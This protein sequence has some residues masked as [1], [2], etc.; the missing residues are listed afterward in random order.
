[1][2]AR[3]DTSVRTYEDPYVE[4]RGGVSAI[5]ILTGVL[6]AVGAWFLLTA[7][8]LAGLAAAGLID[9][10]SGVDTIEAGVGAGVA[11]V[12]VEFLAY[13]WGGYT[14]GR[15]ARGAGAINGV[16]V[17]ILSLVV[18]GLIVAAVASLGYEVSINMPFEASRLPFE[19]S[20]AVDYGLGFGIAA[21]AA[22]LLGGLFGGIAGA[23]WHAR[24]ERDATI[25]TTTTGG[26]SLADKARLETE[27][28]RREDQVIRLER[29][30][31]ATSAPAPVRG[32]TDTPPPPPAGGLSDKTTTQ[33][34][35]PRIR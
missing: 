35:A 10:E 15:M 32:R 11:L 1:M 18:G 33:P 13:L 25:A 26:L 5:G 14:A 28:A 6:V 23:R 21:L 19:G 31:A 20:T 24:L 16:L 27:R 2:A 22:M 34:T 30:A 17:P 12:A 4:A 7:L 29:Q 9:L 8:V 3:R